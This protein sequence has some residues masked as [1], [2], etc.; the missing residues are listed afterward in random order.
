[1]KNANNNTGDTK[2][3]DVYG[4]YA[5]TRVPNEER[6]SFLS[7][8]LVYNGVVI[9]AAA[10]WTGHALAEG[11]N[12][13]NCVIATII[14]FTITGII[15]GAL[16]IVGAREGVSS[17]MLAR[18]VFG[19]Y[20]AIIIGLIFAITNW[21]W[22][23]FQAGF[24]GTVINTMFPGHFFTQPQIAALW[25]G[26]L[27]MITAAI[28]YEGVAFLSFLAIPLML[29]IIGAGDAAL[30]SQIGFQKI[31]NT[32]PI[33]PMTLAQGITL[34]AGGMAVG[35]VISP[36][37][38]RYAKKDS[39]A[40]WGFFIALVVVNN[41]VII[42]GAALAHGTGSPN[43]P[44]AMTMAGLGVSSL[45]MLILAQWTTNDNNLYSTTLAL[46]NL[47][48]I[49]KSILTVILGVTASIAAYLGIADLLVPFLNFLGTYIPPIGGIMLAHYFLI[50]PI[51]YEKTNKF[52][53]RYGPG[54]EYHGIDILAVIFT[55]LSGFIGS[56]I[57]G[58]SA[59]NSLIVGFLGYS[60]L[61]FLFEKLDIKY[62]YGKKT[63]SDTGY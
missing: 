7:T 22:Y 8:F 25:G 51:C 28:G 62:K 27:M 54:T 58:I 17:T 3:I 45:V 63:E 32:Q 59:I 21:G 26:L 50:T 37:V 24:F 55:F 60:L 41:F 14:G 29:V 20:G 38:S 52:R 12:L 39:H 23:G 6:R 42:S 48:P 10:L 57:P 49:K 47:I 5:I 18:H 34:A 31:L 15:G 2:S 11:L 44:E 19:R 36:D 56:K 30:I 46:I 1:M 40:F 13:I 9:C 35:S 53:Y 33:N 16:G 43:L 4:D 61:A